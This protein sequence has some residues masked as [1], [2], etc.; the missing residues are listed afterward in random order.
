MADIISSISALT[1]T[2]PTTL[3]TTGT[4]PLLSTAIKNA[5]IDSVNFSQDAKDLFQISQ[6]DNDIFSLLGVK[7]PLSTKDIGKLAKK[8]LELVNSGQIRLNSV[9]FDEILQIVNSLNES[10]EPQKQEMIASLTN[11]LYSFTQLQALNALTGSSNE[12]LF[13]TNLNS[14]LLQTS[15][16]TDA[17][18]ELNKLAIPL[19]S[20]LLNTNSKEG[21]GFLDELSSIY[22]LNS[23][24]EDEKKQAGYLLNYRNTLLSR[25]L[26]EGNSDILGY[27]STIL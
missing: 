15:F 17:I 11:A 9:N 23:L 1:Q 25:L 5:I 13:S 2:F 7:E 4:K 27:T 26:I 19:S 8:A 24:N 21:E 18:K 16:S 20:V 6:I 3:S 10:E 12:N 14:L 22:G